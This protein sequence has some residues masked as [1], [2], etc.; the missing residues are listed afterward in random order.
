[1]L[2]QETVM[3]TSFFKMIL[4]SIRLLEIKK[5]KKR[6]VDL[7]CVYYPILIYLRLLLPFNFSFFLNTISSIPFLYVDLPVLMS[8]RWGIS[9]T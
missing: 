5:N 8:A 1:V 3:M 7:E 2:L 6:E 4:G 9:I